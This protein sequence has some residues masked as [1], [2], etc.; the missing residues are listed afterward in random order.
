M[1][2]SG[3]I[4]LAKY[5]GWYSV[6]EEAYF[7]EGEL[8]DGP[9]GAR[10]SPNGTPVEWVEEESYFFRLSAYAGPPARPLR[11]EPGFHHARQVPQR[12]RRAS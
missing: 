7:D 1:E 6:R 5:S 2:E 11:G 12:D 8:T 3:D 10:N 4:Y 9:N